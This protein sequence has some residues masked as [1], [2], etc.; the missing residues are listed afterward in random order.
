MTGIVDKQDK[1]FICF[2][3]RV[4][5]GISLHPIAF[6]DIQGQWVLNLWYARAKID[7]DCITPILTVPDRAELNE[8][9]KDHFLM[10]KM[11]QCMASDHKTTHRQSTVICH[12]W[13]VRV[14]TGL[15]QIPIPQQKYLSY[16]PC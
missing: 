1:M 11:S 16:D 8:M 14:D 12:S 10:L 4:G 7:M 3:K 15:L 6:D 2:E 13:K 5:G 9:C